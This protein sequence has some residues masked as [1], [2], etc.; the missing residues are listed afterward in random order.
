MLDHDAIARLIPHQGAMCLL[1]RVVAQNATFITCEAD[2]HADPANP[3]RNSGGLPVTAG[4]EYAAQA[5]ALHAALR[6]REG[7][8]AGRGFLAVLSDVRW[9]HERLDDLPGPLTIHIDLLADTGGGL[10]YRFTVGSQA[11]AP[12]LEGVQVVAKATVAAP[13]D[14]P[15]G[16]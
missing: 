4:V 16:A 6:K 3:L 13:P 5:I 12:V 1:A 10:Q 11:G 9:T 7:G 15:T 2:N 14:V 8:P